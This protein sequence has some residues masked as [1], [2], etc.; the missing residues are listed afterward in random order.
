MPA[1]GRLEDLEEAIRVYQQAVARTPPDSPDLPDHLNNLG[2]GLRDRYAR[3]GRLEDLEEAIRRL[4]AGGGSARRPTRPTCPL[5]STTWAPA[6][7]TAMPAAATWTTW[8]RPSGVYQQAVQ[9]T[10]PDSPDLPSRLN[11]LGNGLRDRYARTGHLED[12]E[13]AIRVYRAGRAAH[14][15]RLARPARLP[16]QPG[17]RPE[18]PLRPQRAPGGPGGGPIRLPR[19][20][21]RGQEVAA[22]EVLGPA[23]QLGTIGPWAP[24]WAEALPGYGYG[25]PPWIAC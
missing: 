22:E 16:Q 15:A 12:L 5:T 18:R 19:A 24:A 20:C 4:S 8:K 13:E 1:R 2:T 14:P 11:N 25:R 21:Q 9:R 7:A 23:A 17:H 3:T 6:C 10:P